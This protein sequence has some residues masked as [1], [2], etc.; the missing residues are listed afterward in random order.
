MTVLRRQ[1]KSGAD[2]PLEKVTGHQDDR[3]SITETSIRKHPCWETAAGEN[4]VL[5][6]T[7]LATVLGN[8]PNNNFI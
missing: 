3:P 8:H 2:D 7:L 5:N 1:I 4:E 6:N